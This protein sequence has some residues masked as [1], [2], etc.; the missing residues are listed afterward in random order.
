[1][2]CFD[3]VLPNLA[4]T[5]WGESSLREVALWATS[6]QSISKSQNLN[7]DCHENATH[8]LVM[9]AWERF[10]LRFGLL[11]FGNAKSRNDS[12]G[13]FDSPR[14][15]DFDRFCVFYVIRRIYPPLTPP[16][17]RGKFWIQTSQGMGEF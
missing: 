17:G 6:W 4:M 8:F 9:T 13:F 16:Q 2:D 14:N 10:A 11:R 12:V 1:M 15:D 3:S 7:V 5:K